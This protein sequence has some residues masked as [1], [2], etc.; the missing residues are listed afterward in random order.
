MDKGARQATV[1]DEDS[2]YKEVQNGSILS[3]PDGGPLSTI[4]RK[5]GAI[6]M[7]RTTGPSYMKEVFEISSQ[8]GWRHYFFGSTIETLGKLQSR[9]VEEYPNLQIVGMYSPPFRPLS[10]EED[11]IITKE[12]NRVSPDF[13]WVGL[14]APKQEVWMAN[15]QGRIK[16]LMIGVGAGFDYFA[17]NIKRAPDWMQRSNLEWLYRLLQDPK[18]LF[19]RYI[20][21]NSKFIW[22]AVIKGK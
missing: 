21:T 4:G 15:H 22:E 16:G 2:N 1:H 9:L 5:R 12:I 18:R 20:K 6:G 8:Y 13:I 11:E 10:K 14:G 17:G 19:K 3:I 7:A